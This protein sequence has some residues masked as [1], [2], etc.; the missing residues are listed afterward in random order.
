M[1][2]GL[3]SAIFTLAEHFRALYD[4]LQ[5][6]EEFPEPNRQ[7]EIPSMAI[8]SPGTP[9]IVN[10]MPTLH[11]KTVNED[12]Q[13]FYDA[14][15]NIGQYNV[16]LQIDLWT[17]YKSRRFE[18]Y[19]YIMKGFDHQFINGDLPQGLSLT[20]DDYHDAIARYDVVGYNYGD[21]EESSQRSEWRMTLNVLATFPRLQVKTISLITEAKIE[22]EITM[23]GWHQIKGDQYFE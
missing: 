15:Y 10:L 11:K 3:D 21:N 16:S 8:S 1:K 9:E 5:V 13:N 23:N 14:V 19:E 4:D 18:W 17:E 22:H 7:L 20:M 6:L 12:D 2:S